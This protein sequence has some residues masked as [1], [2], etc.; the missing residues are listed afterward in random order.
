RISRRAQRQAQ[1]RPFSHL[2]TPSGPT[3]PSQSCSALVEDNEALK[4]VRATIL[5][6]EILYKI[7]SYHYHEKIS[8]Q[9]DIWINSAL[10]AGRSTGRLCSKEADAAFFPGHP[11]AGVSVSWPSLVLEV[12]LSESLSQLRTDAH[13]WYAN[14][15]H[16]TQLVILISADP[17]SHDADIG[18]WTQVV[19]QRNGVTTRTGSQ[20][21]HFLE[22]TKCTTSARPRDGV[23]SGD[24]LE[25][26]FRTLMRRPPQ[27]LQETVLQ[28]TPFWIQRICQ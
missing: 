20:N 15:H 13:W 11:A 6:H 8:R 16:Q 3:D 17:N 2:A 14:S 4:R 22:C 5:Y 24:A 27:N 19:N 10:G 23:V 28:L 12:G 18:I 7:M 9:F 25:I 1:V 21:T 26:D